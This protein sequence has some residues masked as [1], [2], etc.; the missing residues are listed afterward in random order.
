MPLNDCRAPR[1][2]FAI[3]NGRTAGLN[4][5]PTLVIFFVVLSRFPSLSGKADPFTRSERA[6]RSSFGNRRFKSALL[7]VCVFFLIFCGKKIGHAFKAYAEGG[8]VVQKRRKGRLN[9][10]RYP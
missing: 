3:K 1:K 6:N 8:G 10:P 7:F 9:D 4:S 2:N 5:L